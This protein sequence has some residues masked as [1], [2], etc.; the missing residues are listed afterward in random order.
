MLIYLLKKIIDLEFKEKC[1]VIEKLMLLGMQDH[2][3]EFNPLLLKSFYS[4]KEFFIK[5]LEKN[6][7]I[8]IESSKKLSENLNI[9]LRTL[10]RLLKDLKD[11]EI[12]EKTDTQIFI[13][14]QFKLDKY[15]EQFK[16]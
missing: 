15:K 11:S 3:K 6:K 14:D 5:H 8:D 13:K 7:R 4:D 10:Q 16:K 2:F 1:K 12:I 9:N